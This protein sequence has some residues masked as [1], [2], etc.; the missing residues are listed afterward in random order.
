MN[1]KI[2]KEIEEVTQIALPYFA[3]NGHNYYK[4]VSE[5]RTNN[6]AVSF[7]DT[8]MCYGIENYVAPERAF[9][10]NCKTI[11]EE[12]FNQVFETVLKKLTSWK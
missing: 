8:S 12:E 11:T 2:K 7:Y 9:G 6:I 3:T 5:N 10:I 4:I 1:V